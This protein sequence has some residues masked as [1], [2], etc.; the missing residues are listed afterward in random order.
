MLIG[1]FKNTCTFSLDIP[2]TIFHCNLFLR[3]TAIKRNHQ[4]WNKHLT[5][6]LWWQLCSISSIAIQ[7]CSL[8][9]FMV[10]ISFNWCFS[11]QHCNVSYLAS[12]RNPAPPHTL[13][14]ENLFQLAAKNSFPEP[15]H[16]PQQRRPGVWVS[17]SCYTLSQPALGDQWPLTNLAVVGG[18]M[19]DH[20]RLLD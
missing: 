19:K 7:S 2:S 12:I 10:V 16:I 9:I 4:D 8:S 1:K 14:P 15:I 5:F 11:H 6:D 13:L 20:I 3:K 17:A 18:G